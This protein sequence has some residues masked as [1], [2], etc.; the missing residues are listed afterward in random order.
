MRIYYIIVQHPR[1]TFCI[2][3]FLLTPPISWR[4][5]IISS[6]A[7]VSGCWV[8][9]LFRPKVH[10]EVIYEKVQTIA[11]NSNQVVLRVLVSPS[12][13]LLRWWILSLCCNLVSMLGDRYLGN[14]DVLI[15]LCCKLTPIHTQT[16]CHLNPKNIVYTYVMM[17]YD[18]I[19][20]IYS[21]YV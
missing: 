16:S 21:V 2:I 17:R 18:T 19:Y 14:S 13:S 11:I 8:G 12:M 6:F 5:G 15:S 20:T 10:S 4:P 3:L 7:N 9:L 1:C